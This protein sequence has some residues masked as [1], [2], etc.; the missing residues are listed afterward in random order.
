MKFHNIDCVGSLLF[1]RLTSAQRGSTSPTQGRVVFDTDL[2][3]MYYADGIGWNEIGSGSSGTSET[4]YPYIDITGTSDEGGLLTKTQVGIGTTSGSYSVFGFTGAT[5]FNTSRIRGLYI[6]C[7]T[8]QVGLSPESSKITCTYP[9]GSTKIILESFNHLTAGQEGTGVETIILVPLNQNTISITI[10]AIC[11]DAAGS[12]QYEIIGAVQPASTNFSIVMPT[13][14]IISYA[15]ANNVSGWRICG[16]DAINRII[17]SDLFAIIGTT[18]GNGDGINTFNIPDLRGRFPVGENPL[19][20]PVPIGY[21]RLPPGTVRSSVAGGEFEH[22]LT[23][24]E[25]PNH[26]H[27]ANLE[28]HYNGVATDYIGSAYSSGG[29]YSSYAGGDQPHPND[30]P[31]QTAIYL[32]KT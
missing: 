19:S 1:Q 31:Y 2:N 9:D 23:I 18:Y 21:D 27:K 5:G 25:L 26:A 20:G 7:R 22:T 24:A 4:F 14:S 28:K 12:A 17:F 32:I 30:P 11:T 15:R 3:K 29:Y 13:G 8:R 10:E 6:K 16:G